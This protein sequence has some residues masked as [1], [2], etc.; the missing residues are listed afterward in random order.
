MFSKQITTICAFLR[1][2]ITIIQNI[3]VPIYVKNRN[4]VT[5]HG[6]DCNTW[7]FSREINFKITVFFSVDPFTFLH[8]FITVILVSV[9]A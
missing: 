4:S 1:H 7:S 8:N 9:F 6:V 2:S 3:F 5:V